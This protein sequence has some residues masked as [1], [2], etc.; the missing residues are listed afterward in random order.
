MEPSIVLES[1]NGTQQPKIP[2]E[3]VFSKDAGR[4]E[5]DKLEPIAVIGYSCRFPQDAYNPQ[6]F[7][8][9]LSNARCTSTPVPKDRFN[10]ESFYHPD[11]ARVNSYNIK[12]GH[13]L[14]EDP[15]FFDAP[16][17]N[18]SPSEAACMD[19]QQ[20]IL[21]ESAYRCFENGGFSSRP[22]TVQC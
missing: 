10:V 13:F 1:N 14:K 12:G 16:F 5:N 8:E 11:P 3:T 19:P 6:K 20:R 18:M 22:L 9:L 21:M 7:W 4:L 2:G 15:G 17:F